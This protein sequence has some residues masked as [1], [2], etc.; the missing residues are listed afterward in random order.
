[1]KTIKAYEFQDLDPEIQVK[2]KSRTLNEVIE[3]ELDLLQAELDEG[4]ISEKKYYKI[5]G[6]SKFYADSTPWF[7]PAVYYENH[8]KAIDKAV[9]EKVKDW[10]FN[11]SG[12]FIEVK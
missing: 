9:S 10:L 8:K 3:A 4:T 12:T 5:V 11:S 7:V 2:V 6:C 1:M